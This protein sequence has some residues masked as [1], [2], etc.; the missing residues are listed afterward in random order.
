[1]HMPL[2]AIGSD[3]YAKAMTAMIRMLMRSKMSESF[4]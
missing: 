4:I 3:E 1:M 2:I